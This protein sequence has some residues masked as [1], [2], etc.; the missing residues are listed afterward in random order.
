[1]LTS[2]EPW[3]LK[4]GTGGST[5]PAWLAA[6]DDLARALHAR[7]VTDTGSGHG[8][9]VEQPRLVVDAVHEVVDETRK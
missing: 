6:Q 7:H 8:I 5:W 2:D 1:M 9:A 4:V 3:D